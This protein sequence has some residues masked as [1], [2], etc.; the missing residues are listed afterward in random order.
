MPR[1]AMLLEFDGRAFCGSQAQ[2]DL[3]TVQGELAL[4]LARICGERVVVRPASRLDQGVSAEYFPADALLTQL[5]GADRVAPERAL[6]SLGL[7]MAS[8]LPRD[9]TVRSVAL[10]DTTWHA[11]HAAR[12]KTYRYTVTL[13]GTKPVLAPRCWW[14]RR[15]DHPERLQPMAELLLGNRDL[16]LF[17]NLRHDGSDGEVRDRHILQSEWRV[18]G[19]DLVFRIRGTGFLYKQIRGFV[20]AMIHV[21]QNHRHV[22]EFAAIVAGDASIGRLGNIAPPEGL[23]LEHVAYDPE[24]VWLRL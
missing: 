17:A 3:R 18:H 4:A 21:A 20:G 12:Q 1:V 24:P 13:R 16:R 22:D 8:E 6:R 19:D 5:P 7:A 15:L 14:V 11:Q 2:A 9:I 23:M 10:V